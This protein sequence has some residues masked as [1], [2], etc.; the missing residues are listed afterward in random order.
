[1]IIKPI[2]GID[3]YYATDD[4]KI[5]KEIKG[6]ITNGGYLSAHLFNGKD[7]KIHRLIAQT[8][9]PNPSNLPQVNHLDGDKLNNDV[10]NLE[11]TSPSGNVRHAYDNGLID[12]NKISAGLRSYH[13]K[14]ATDES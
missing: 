2:P 8:F 7:Y 5:F 9:I 3:G 6:R 1:M 10:N 4:G 11:W 12:R 14:E 13:E